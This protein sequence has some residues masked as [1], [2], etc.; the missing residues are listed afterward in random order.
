MHAALPPARPAQGLHA[1]SALWPP[2]PSPS[3]GAPSGLP[4][5]SGPARAATATT[6]IRGGAD[7]PPHREG[8]GPLSPVPPGTS[9]GDP[10]HLSAVAE[11]AQATRTAAAVSRPDVRRPR[12]GQH[13]MAFPVE[14][15]PVRAIV[16]WGRLAAL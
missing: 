12:R 7:A 3:H 2:G 10:D 13:A 15:L 5:P 6:G 4:A 9:G 16:A 11:R 14:P 1:H 8:Y